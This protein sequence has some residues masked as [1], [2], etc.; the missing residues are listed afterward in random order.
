[1][2][3]QAD[4]VIVGGDFEI[5]S[6]GQSNLTAGVMRIKGDFAQYGTA[7]P[8]GAGNAGDYANARSFYVYGGG[9]HT[10]ELCGL[11]KQNVLFEGSSRFDVLRCTKLMSNYTFN[12]EPCWN[13]LIQMKVENPFADVKES[14]WQYTFVKYALDHNLMSGKGKDES[15]NILFDPESSMTRAE[16]VQTLYNKEG[17]EAVTYTARFTDVPDNQWYTDAILWAAENNIVAGKGDKFDVSGKITREEMATILYKYATNYKG[18]ETAGRAEFT[19]YTDASSIS[20]WATE[21]MKWA[22]HYGIMKGKKEALAPKDNATRAECATM[23][24]NFM[25]A[26]E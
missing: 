4:E 15:G 6:S 13:T 16:F 10:V 17:K 3:D 1:M 9:N 11:G 2:D 26:Y 19:G 18:Y 14:S 21:N 23:L 20:G 8:N 12:P 25:K 7:I 24:S 5:C 22:L